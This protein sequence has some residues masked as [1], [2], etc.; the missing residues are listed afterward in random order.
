MFCWAVA[1]LCVGNPGAFRARGSW[2]IPGQASPAS[3]CASHFLF[4]RLLQGPERNMKTHFLRQG[5]RETAGEKQN[6]E[7]Q[8]G[9]G[10][11]KTWPGQQRQ[12]GA[13]GQRCQRAEVSD[14]MGWPRSRGGELGWARGFGSLDG[15][16]P[17]AAETRR[18]SVT[19]RCTSPAACCR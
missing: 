13:K 17:Q 12:H 4:D 1:L 6:W 5:Q 15:Q 18:R 7:R 3:W 10:W 9:W 8:D 16:L 14:R 2:R 11:R 19:L